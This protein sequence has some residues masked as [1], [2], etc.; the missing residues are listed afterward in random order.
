VFTP[1]REH[2]HGHVH[3]AVAVA[4]HVDV[5]VDVEVIV[6]VYRDGDVA[7]IAKRGGSLALSTRQRLELI[8]QIAGP[9]PASHAPSAR[10]RFLRRAA[11]RRREG[12]ACASL[13]LKLRISLNFIHARTVPGLL[14]RI[15][16]PVA[17][18]SALRGAAG[19]NCCARQDRAEAG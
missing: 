9:R 19:R 16:E 11:G 12:E 2:A 10:R 4:A 5:D 18:G 17:E 3:V 13:M 7:V 14:R 8:R 15:A 1:P 6:D